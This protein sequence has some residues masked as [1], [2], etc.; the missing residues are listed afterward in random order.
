M[1]PQD[2]RR[3]RARC[4]G[5]RGPKA[6]P[7][8]RPPAEIYHHIRPASGFQAS[9]QPNASTASQ[10]VGGHEP[11]R[12]PK[13][14]EQGLRGERSPR[15]DTCKSGARPD[16]RET[17]RHSRLPKPARSDI[18]RRPPGRVPNR[19]PTQ[20][21]NQQRR[22]P[23]RRASRPSPATRARDAG[24]AKPPARKA[25]DQRRHDDA[26]RQ[27][28]PRPTRSAPRRATC[29]AGTRGKCRCEQLAAVKRGK[30]HAADHFDRSVGQIRAAGEHLNPADD[31][32]YRGGEPFD[33]R[34]SSG[35]LR[36]AIATAAAKSNPSQH[37]HVVVPTDRPLAC[38]A[39]RPGRNNP[40]PAGTR[41][42][43]TF[44]KLPTAPPTRRQPQGVD[45]LQRRC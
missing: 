1:T 40:R 31:E 30:D 20:R 6:R 11:P 35:D 28:M 24:A 27:P 34:V 7:F 42:T 14:P 29:K 44:K 23:N 43:T 8:A 32:K 16:S 17:D 22:R 38:R 10:A 21:S 5:Q 26:N 13:S 12:G 36:P 33:D 41:Y 25:H 15:V 18:A 9:T 39:V 2:N 3:G 19:S 4:P 37:R 45:H